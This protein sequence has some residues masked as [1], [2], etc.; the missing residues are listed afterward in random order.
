[1]LTKQ[2]N[3]LAKIAVT[4][5][6][7]LSISF[8][9]VYAATV[10]PV[11]NTDNNTAQTK[12]EEQQVIIDNSTIKMVVTETSIAYLKPDTN[13][14]KIYSITGGTVVDADFN[15]LGSDFVTILYHDTICYMPF[16][17]LKAIIGF[18]ETT[19]AKINKIHETYKYDAENVIEIIKAPKYYSVN[20]TMLYYNYQDFI[21][22]LCVKWGIE[23]YYTTILCQ[24]YQESRYNQNA[25]SHTN[26]HGICQLNERYHSSFTSQAG[27]PE[28][29]VKTD[30][31]AN[32]YCGVM[33]MAN[34]IKNRNGNIDIAMTDYNAGGGYYGKYGI[35][36][37]YTN[38]VHNWE[39]TL[40]LV[41]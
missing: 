8:N 20:G 13:S 15:S 19:I 32:M 6:L 12:P 30:P 31:Y 18:N 33:I 14:R 26:D 7:L 5:M 39:Q 34:N 28:W 24:F 25:V 11:V 10:I 16:D 23:N 35:R 3:G 2:K 21:W 17:R 29:N 36:Y 41:K 22:T 27:Y 40:K 37:Q 1:M 9:S 4:I 38:A